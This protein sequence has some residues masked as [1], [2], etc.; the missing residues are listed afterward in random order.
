MRVLVWDAETRWASL[1]FSVLTDA[2]R[3]TLHTE[4][5]ITSGLGEVGMAAVY[6]RCFLRS[7]SG[8]SLAGRAE[9]TLAFI[10]AAILFLPLFVFPAKN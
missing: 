2:E 4:K 5:N 10:S 8:S 6:G 3:V 9:F 7:R 1:I